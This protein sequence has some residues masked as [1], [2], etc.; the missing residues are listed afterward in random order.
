MLYKGIKKVIDIDKIF[1][2]AVSVG[3][4]LNKEEKKDFL[5]KGYFNHFVNLTGDERFACRWMHIN[6]KNDL[7]NCWFN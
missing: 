1:E 7:Y 4:K 2:D 6:C 5:R 3:E